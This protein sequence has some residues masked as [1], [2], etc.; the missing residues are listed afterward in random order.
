MEGSLCGVS[1]GLAGRSAEPN[2]E[3]PRMSAFQD[4][5]GAADS[6]RPFVAFG[7][8]PRLYRAALPEPSAVDACPMDS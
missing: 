8:E 5:V 6:R 1:L 3:T 4:E 7:P 2:T